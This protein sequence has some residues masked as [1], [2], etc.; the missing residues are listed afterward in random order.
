M[1]QSCISSIGL[2][3][4]FFTV[5]GIEPGASHI[6][7]RLSIIEPA[8][9]KIPSFLL[10]I[11][12]PS[13]QWVVSLTCLLCASNFILKGGVTEASPQL[14]GMRNLVQVERM[15][16]VGGHQTRQ[17]KRRETTKLNMWV[18]TA[19]RGGGYPQGGNPKAVGTQGQARTEEVGDS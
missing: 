14:K 18:H 9:C 17:K 6:L 2:R 15:S 10:Q 12:S 4:L 7:G 1:A 3:L 11:G 19:G 5:L 8:L 13:G 16:S